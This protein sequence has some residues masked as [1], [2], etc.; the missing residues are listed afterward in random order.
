M[1]LIPHPDE[2]P[3]LLPLPHLHPDLILRDFKMQAL[4][5]HN[6]P[7]SNLTF[8]GAYQK[9]C[10]PHGHIYPF[11]SFALLESKPLSPAFNLTKMQTKSCHFKNR[12]I[13][14]PTQFST[15]VLIIQV[16]AWTVPGVNY[17]VINKRILK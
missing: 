5:L 6:F 14:I 4:Y 1:T 2:H 10:K 11:L 12:T 17:G 15:I 9:R 16:P 8:D 13:V 3:P 7:V